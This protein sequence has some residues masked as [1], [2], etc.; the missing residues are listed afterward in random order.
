MRLS[1]TLAREL[2]RR[3]QERVAESDGVVAVGFR[4]PV[5][6]VLPP[7]ALSGSQTKAP[8]FAGGYLLFKGV[9][10]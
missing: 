7:A 1:G 3:R 2:A 10:L 4:S 5:G 8:G 9:G 6:G